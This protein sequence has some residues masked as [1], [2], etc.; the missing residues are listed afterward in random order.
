MCFPAFDV[1]RWGAA[2]PGV[3]P[4]LKVEAAHQGIKEE[5]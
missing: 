2:L 3:L 4:S 5:G 1:P